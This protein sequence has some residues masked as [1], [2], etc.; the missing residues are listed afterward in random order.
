[1]SKHTILDIGSINTRIGFG[2]KPAPDHVFPTVVGEVKS[3]HAT[4]LVEDKR[5]HFIGREALQKRALVR[6]QQPV[7]LGI[8]NMRQFIRLAK[9]GL[10]KASG[11]TQLVLLEPTQATKQMREELVDCMFE[12][13]D[14]SEV[15]LLSS[16]ACSLF[17][18]GRTTGVVVEAG[19][20]QAHIVP[21]LEGHALAR[22]RWGRSDLS[23]LDITIKFQTTLQQ[24]GRLGGIDKDRY[25]HRIREMKE[26]H[27]YASLNIDD[28]E[29]QSRTDPESLI[30]LYELPDGR[31]IEIGE[32]RFRCGEY[33]FHPPTKRSI[34]KTIMKTITDCDERLQPKLF[35]N[36]VTS[37]GVCLMR[38]FKARLQKEINVW[39][40]ASE[41]G[42]EL[43]QRF[44]FQK[45]I[46]LI[47]FEKKMEH[48]VC[49]Q[50]WV[51]AS[52]LSQLST[53]DGLKITK[54]DVKENG[55]P[56]IH[57]KEM[58]PPKK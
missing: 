52:I 38:G 28:D 1:M 51:G 33:F 30:R 47:N 34:H 9:Y 56:V 31:A 3:E 29:H 43:K 5:T 17:A 14:A 26:Q 53:F 44:K 55:L 48:N 49:I 23:G 2:G 42:R 35:R 4:A 36:I 10:E 15:W 57:K 37:G 13:L 24:N 41:D 27:S 50:S 12:E 39:L 16:P 21:F 19:E 45:A 18:S 46:Q 8:P 54:E 11:S 6:L 40:N 58:V 32:E 20:S 25:L 22:S 7:E